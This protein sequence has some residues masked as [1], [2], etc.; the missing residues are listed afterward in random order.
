MISPPSL[1]APLIEDLHLVIGGKILS[2][3]NVEPMDRISAS[4]WAFRM[5]DAGEK[6]GREVVQVLG[7]VSLASRRR[8]NPEVL[9]PEVTKVSPL[10][11]CKS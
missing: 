5:N 8:H 9:V 4:G 1:N 6:V 10:P 11:T 2:L 7:S 3:S